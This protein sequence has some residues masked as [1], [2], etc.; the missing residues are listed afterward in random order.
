MAG[1]PGLCFQGCLYSDQS[2][3]IKSPA[4]A[5]GRFTH[6]HG[7]ESVGQAILLPIKKIRI[8][9]KLE[10]YKLSVTFLNTTLLVFGNGIW[11]TC[12]NAGALPAAITMSNKIFCF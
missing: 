3:K 12:T 5:N 2:W 7:G 11:R 6:S 8:Q 9:K 1:H 10:F 4:G